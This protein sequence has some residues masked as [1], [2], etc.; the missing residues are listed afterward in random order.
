MKIAQVSHLT[1]ASNST[2][3]AV[4]WRVQRQFAGSNGLPKRLSLNEDE[5]G[6]LVG[7]QVHY[8][9]NELKSLVSSQ[10][11][12]GG[13]NFVLFT[14]IQATKDLRMLFLGPAR[15]LLSL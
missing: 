9:V 6:F 14:D 12:L 11:G 1:R 3:G 13:H 15:E 2:Y 4:A 10:K 7:C 8:M 5:G